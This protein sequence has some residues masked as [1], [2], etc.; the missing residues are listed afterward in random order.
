MTNIAKQTL[1][2]LLHREG[3][4]ESTTAYSSILADSSIE[5]QRRIS[6]LKKYQLESIQLE[7]Q[8]Y[9][10]VHQLESEFEPLFNS[11]VEKVNILLFL[12]LTY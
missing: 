9:T 5:V 6:A 2:S 10:R 4:N 12:F 3:Y 1:S 7:S 8:F 11:V